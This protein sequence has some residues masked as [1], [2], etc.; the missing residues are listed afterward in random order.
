MSGTG[1]SA[2]GRGQ[3]NKTLPAIPEGTLRPRRGQIARS[4]KLECRYRHA[5]IIVVM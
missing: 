5:C 4:N 3:I 1:D 2:V